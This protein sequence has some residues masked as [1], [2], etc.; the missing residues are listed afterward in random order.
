MKLAEVKQYIDMETG[1]A[2]TEIKSM[3]ESKF[4]GTAPVVCT[5]PDGRKIPQTKSFPIEASTLEEAFN[6]F[7][8]SLEATILKEAEARQKAMSKIQIA[9]SVPN[10]GNIVNLFDKK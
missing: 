10:G 3:T 2:V 4:Q 5:M 9:Q 6:V 1:N 8:P 7:K